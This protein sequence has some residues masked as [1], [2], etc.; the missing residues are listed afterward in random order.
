MAEEKIEKGIISEEALEEIA[1]GIGI[2]K[3]TLKKVAIGSGVII[4]V[5]GGTVGGAVGGYLLGKKRG[6]ENANSNNGGFDENFQNDLNEINNLFTN[7]NGMNSD[8]RNAWGN[9]YGKFNQR[10]DD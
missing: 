9:F 5:V 7:D 10:N 3:E 4:G 1:G 6:E 2:S 8:T